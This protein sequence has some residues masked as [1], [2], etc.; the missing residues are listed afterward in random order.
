MSENTNGGASQEI[1]DTIIFENK[2]SEKMISAEIGISQGSIKVSDAL[3]VTALD[4]S[5]SEIETINVLR[6]KELVLDCW[7]KTTLL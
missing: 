2:E 3:A 6:C 4:L 1:N 5:D 7:R